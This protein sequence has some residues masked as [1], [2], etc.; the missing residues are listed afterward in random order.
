[1]SF[2]PTTATIGRCLILGL[3]LAGAVSGC[4]NRHSIKVGSVPDDYRTNHPIMIAE[5]QRTLDLAV[6]SSDRGATRSQRTAIEGFLTNY[7]KSAAPVLNIMVPDGASNSVAASDAARD[8]ASIAHKNG[9]PDSRVVITGYQAG[10]AEVAAPVRLSFTAI[11]AQT[12]KCGRWPEDILAKG[13][14]NKHYANF[15]CSY[16]NNLA[17]QIADPNDLLGPR[18]PS[19][20]DAEDRGAV[21]DEYRETVTVLTPASDE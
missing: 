17:A 3:V 19:E 4:A 16:Q 13:D 10:S 9:V 18:K 2:K 11:A 21:I 14:D 5:K 8:F 1:M 20:I 12:D 7:D 15:G 6:G